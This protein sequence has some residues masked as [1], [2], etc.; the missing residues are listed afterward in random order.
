MR[1]I[2]FSLYCL[3]ATVSICSCQK[4]MNSEEIYNLAS[5]GVVLIVNEYYYS[6]KLNSLDVF[7]TGVDEDGDPTDLTTDEDEVRQKC[8]ECTGTGFFISSD[9]QIMTNRHVASPKIEKSEVSKN[10]RKAFK[11]V[12]KEERDKLANLWH[13]YEGNSST[14]NEIYNEWNTF[15]N[16]YESVDEMSADDIQITTHADLYIVY[17]DTHVVKED[18]LKPCVTVALS[19]D[20][21]VDLAIIQLKDS[22][23]P[24]NAY[25]FSL[26]PEED[27]KELTLDERLFMIAFNAGTKVSKTKQGFRSQIYGGHVTQRSD[28]EQILYSIASL[29]GSSGSPV[30]DQYGYLVA[31]NYAKVSGTQGF[32][33]GIPSRLVRQFLKDN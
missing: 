12:F 18:D 27:E 28:G 7:F 13:Q 16:A 3:L 23:T 30:I 21:D 4:K 20:E 31:V 29:P 8:Y 5:S 19:E 32:N 1:Y 11:D 17:N 2:R 26:Y 6:A 10:I 9:G 24:E 22:E 14:Q 33:Y 25:V 15:N